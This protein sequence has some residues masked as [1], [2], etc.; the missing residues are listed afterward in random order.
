ML[1]YELDY[2]RAVGFLVDGKFVR[3][4]SW[5]AGKYIK[6]VKKDDTFKF[7]IITEDTPDDIESYEDLPEYTATAEDSIA[8]DW[9]VESPEKYTIAIMNNSFLLRKIPKGHADIKRLMQDKTV[10]YIYTGIKYS[11]I[12]DALLNILP[13][14]KM[15]KGIE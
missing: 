9:A 10:Q 6:A 14:E 12:K 4:N 8:K 15:I 13:E 3:R 1:N 2:A 11:D 5:D 7:V